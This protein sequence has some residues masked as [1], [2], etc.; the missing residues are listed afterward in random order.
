MSIPSLSL[1]GKVAIVTGARRGNG[2]AIALTLAE[3][4]ADVAVC[5]LVVEDGLLEAVGKKIR[6]FG[7]RSL[8]VQADVRQKTDVDNMVQRVMDEF[9]V[10]DILVNNA[11]VFIAG[12]VLDFSEE[13]WD[14]TID[15]NIKGYYL[16]SQAVGRRMVERKGGNIISIAST[17]SFVLAKEEGPYSISKAGVVMLTKGLAKELASYNIR[18]NAI[19]PGWI[20]TE[21]SREI[22]SQPES[23]YAKQELAKILLGRLGEPSEVA[24][25][26][27]FLASEASSFITGATII[28]D[29]GFIA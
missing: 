8:T 25:V 7:R 29:G 4:G 26:A 28:V 22:W 2:E 15:I 17:N 10:I 6:G 23:E 27:L 1:E 5:D 20:R 13:D 11:G 9:G 18:V 16:C 14:K 3:A 24:N 21:M 12:E 19:A